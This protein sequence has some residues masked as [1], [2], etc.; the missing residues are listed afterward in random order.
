MIYSLAKENEWNFW[1]K[2]HDQVHE[3]VE[4][5]YKENFK[6]KPELF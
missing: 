2:K 5:T 6:W 1:I 3:N 4:N